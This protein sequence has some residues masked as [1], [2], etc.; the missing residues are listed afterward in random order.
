MSRKLVSQTLVPMYT[1]IYVPRVEGRYFYA[2]PRAP[3]AP[4]AGHWTQCHQNGQPEE[5]SGTAALAALRTS[6]Q[7]HEENVRWEKRTSPADSR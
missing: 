1:Q 5:V 7:G 3:L 4:G 2:V 6:H